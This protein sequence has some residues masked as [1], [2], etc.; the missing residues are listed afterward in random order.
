MGEREILSL[1]YG[2]ATEVLEEPWNA[3]RESRDP[4]S[5][6]FYSCEALTTLLPGTLPAADALPGYSTRQRG[7][8]Q[9]P[10]RRRPR[11]NAPGH[12]TNAPAGFK[13]NLTTPMA[14][15]QDEDA[16]SGLGHEAFI[17]TRFA[18]KPSALTMAHSSQRP[19]GKR[20]L[21]CCSRPRALLRSG[22]GLW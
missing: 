15:Y 1:V 12:A 2:P 14:Y 4:T 7:T 8:F 3:D 17:S 22:F 10:T 19:C 6:R 16:A 5:G 20:D 11:L 21:T 18:Y 13:V 9:R